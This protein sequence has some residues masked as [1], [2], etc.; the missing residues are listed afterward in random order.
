MGK[1]S[2]TKGA[3]FERE[4]VQRM[5]EFGLDAERNLT[6]C[7]DGGWD[8]D[9]LAGH[10]ECKK[11]ARL[12]AYLKPAENVRG[13]VYACD[14]GERLV[15]LRVND[16]FKLMADEVAGLKRIPSAADSTFL[17]RVRKGIVESSRS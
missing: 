4:I 17:D 16:A 10:F 5:N 1:T 14:R 13:V 8:I 12:P 3:Q 11:R 15:L 2:R 6:Q 7:R 9:S